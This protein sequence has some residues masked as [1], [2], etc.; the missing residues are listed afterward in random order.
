MKYVLITIGLVFALIGWYKPETVTFWL[1]ISVTCILVIAAA[2]QIYI[3]IKEK[4]EQKKKQ[5]AGKLETGSSDTL[6]STDGNIYP[7]LEM[8]DSGAIFAYAGKPGE[9]L[10]NFFDSSHLIVTKDN[11]RIKVSTVIYDSKGDLVAELVNNEWSVNNN[12]LF[13][14]NFSENELEVKDS[15]G[16]IILQVRAIE[17]RIQLQAKFYGPNGQGVA[18]GK[19]FDEK[20]N[21]GGIMEI[22]GPKHP[23]LK[24]KIHPIFKY[25]SELHIGEKIAP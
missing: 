25:P 15:T 8:G 5:Y 7:K 9:P 17:D 14:R 1:T 24:L 12:T 4:E 22:I 13:D 23:E 16:D 21:P 10:F 20:G 19:G 2:I 18:F 3:L 11:G 6:L